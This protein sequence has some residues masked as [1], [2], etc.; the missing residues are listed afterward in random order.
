MEN[1]KCPYCGGEMKLWDDGCGML[2]YSCPECMAESPVAHTEEEAY[3]AAMKRDRAKGEWIR[4][5]MHNG[6]EQFKCSVCKVEC[7]V[8]ECMYEPI[9]AFCPNC[10]ADMREEEA[11]DEP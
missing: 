8:P 11:I 6:E 5:G 9:Y 2:W 1:P 4:L 3:A 10:G 7:Y